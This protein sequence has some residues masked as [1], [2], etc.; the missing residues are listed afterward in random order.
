MPVNLTGVLSV[1]GI[2][3]GYLSLIRLVWG[4]VRDSRKKPHLKIEFDPVEDL[5]VWD[6]QGSSPRK[7]RVATVHVRN[8]RKAPALRCIAVLRLIS[9]PQGLNPVQK[10]WA[11][12]WADTDYTT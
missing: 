11:L 10:E 2:G 5:Q 12:H 9:A 1:A 7:Q 6:L 4:D 3:A 8:A